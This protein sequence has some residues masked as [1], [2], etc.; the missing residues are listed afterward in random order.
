MGWFILSQI[1]SV[2]VTI[3]SI[4]R[5]SEQDRD[6]EIIILRQQL[7]ILQR[8]QDKPIK[9]NRVEKM[10]LA[11][12]TTKLKA[13]TQRP[14]SRLRDI[15]RIFQ[16]ETV[17]G[18]HR[19]LVRRK[20]TYAHKNKGGRPRIDQEHEALILRLAK[21]NPLW[22]YGK[23]EGE[24]LKLGFQVPRTTVQNVLKRHRMSAGAV[25]VEEF[26]TAVPLLIRKSDFVFVILAAEMDG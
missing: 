9:P 6:L 26:A 7:A 5:L 10:T 4:G 16:P 2:L 8:K 23:I 24:L 22:G 1:F 18:W 17:L 11:V 19:Q 12:L 14:T 13:V 25:S 15:L 3:V 20:W 21:E